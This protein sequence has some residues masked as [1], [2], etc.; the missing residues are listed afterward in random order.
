MAKTTFWDV[1]EKTIEKVGTPLSVKEIWEKANEIGT[2]GDF[3]TNGKT[4]WATIGA[5]CYT[6]IN[7]NGDDSL[8]IQT[9]E[10]PA[11][12]YLRKLA[13]KNDVDKLQKQKDIEQI[14][15]EK[16]ETKKF[17]ERDFIRLLF[18]MPPLTPILKQ[19]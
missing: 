2:I 11:Q 12:F 19:V 6:D 5:Y 4:P 7:N 3:T 18:H 16:I 17:N 15:K 8:V 9:S 1:I 10:R 14:K 13:S